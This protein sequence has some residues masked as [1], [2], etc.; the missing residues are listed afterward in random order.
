MF[1][2]IKKYILNKSADIAAN[3]IKRFNTSL[4][5]M[6]GITISGIVIFAKIIKRHF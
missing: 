6:D 2:F 3:E 4:S 1:G 5:G